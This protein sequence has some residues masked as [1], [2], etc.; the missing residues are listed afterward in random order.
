MPLA[1]GIAVTGSVDQLGRVQ[2]VGSVTEKVE[3][4]FDACRARGLR[5]V[6]GVAVPAANVP[7]LLLREDVVRAAARGRFA[8]Y[9]VRTVEEAM[10]LLCGLPFGVP[11]AA[12]RYPAGTVGG[13]CEAALDELAAAWCRSGGRGGRR[14]GTR[15]APSPE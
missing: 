7:Q 13:R 2:P 12:G 9:P 1:Q 15:L 11:D 14:R 8:V 6:Q 10:E 4:F 5:G 3:G